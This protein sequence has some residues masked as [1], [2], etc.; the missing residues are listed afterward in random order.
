MVSV[1]G[2]VGGWVGG[3]TFSRL[4]K[5]RTRRSMPMQASVP[6]EGGKWVGW[7]GMG[8]MGWVMYV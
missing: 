7:D 4:V 2:W 5:A 3:L 8:G 6:L 1:Y